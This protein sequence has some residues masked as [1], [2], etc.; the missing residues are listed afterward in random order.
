MTR[1][2]MLVVATLTPIAALVSAHLMKAEVP[3]TVRS[4]A[5]GDGADYLDVVGSKKSSVS[6]GVADLQ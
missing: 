3:L 1:M 4:L 5:E 6:A 2:M